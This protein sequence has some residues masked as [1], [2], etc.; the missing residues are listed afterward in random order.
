MRKIFF[1]F[2][3]TLFLSY[4]ITPLYGAGFDGASFEGLCLEKIVE[5]KKVYSIE[6]A[7]ATFGNKRI[8]FFNL[9]LIKVI[10]LEDVNFTLYNDG[11]IVQ[12][13]HFSKAV[14]EL[15][16]K[17]LLDEHGNIVFREQTK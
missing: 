14:Y 2:L 11:Q 13:Q 5:G 17:S 16:S 15:N 1:L 9:A 8:G 12:R 3:L 6:A 7:K 10:N 4:S